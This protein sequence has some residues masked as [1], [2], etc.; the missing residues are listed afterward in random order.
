MMFSAGPGFDVANV[1]LADPFEPEHRRLI[2]ENWN[3]LIKKMDVS[4]DIL[5]ELRH[6]SAITEP[7]LRYLEENTGTL[8]DRI[9]TLLQV[10]MHKSSD[11]FKMFIDCL[12]NNQQHQI[13]KILSKKP[14]GIS[15]ICCS[16]C[17]IFT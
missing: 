9:V 4:H 13:V 7:E 2:C 8:S 3:E 11:Q 16:L 17:F 1:Q 10:M 15:V 12:S 6:R 5:W 14:K